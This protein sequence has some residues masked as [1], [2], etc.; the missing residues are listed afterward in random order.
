MQ[1]CNIPQ[2]CIKPSIFVFSQRIPRWSFTHNS[3]LSPRESLFLINNVAITTKYGLSVSL[4]LNIWWIHGLIQCLKPGRIFVIWNI[5]WTSK[6][7][8]CDVCIVLIDINQHISIRPLPKFYRDTSQNYSCWI[9][10][11]KLLIAC[12]ICRNH[13]KR[14]R[15]A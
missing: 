4:T 11:T 5:V 14:W 10:N 6:W 3:D 12:I 9:Q 13:I 1:D 8:R 2:S 15:K 7:T